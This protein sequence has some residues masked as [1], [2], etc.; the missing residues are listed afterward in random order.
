LSSDE[1]PIAF[2][3]LGS[4][5][6]G[7]CLHLAAALLQNKTYTLKNSDFLDKT[8]FFTEIISNFVAA[9]ILPS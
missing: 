5:L 9:F 3:V 4:I 2:Q 7:A 1:K 6:A 8:V